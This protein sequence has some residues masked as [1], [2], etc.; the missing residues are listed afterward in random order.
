M[1]IL[2]LFQLFTS[3]VLFGL[4]HGL[5]FL[6]VILSLAG[7]GERRQASTKKNQDIY[8]NGYFTVRLSQNEK[9]NIFK[10]LVYY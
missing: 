4:F 3:V 2:Y 5:L 9:G 8:Q 10:I 7:P 6:P 1:I